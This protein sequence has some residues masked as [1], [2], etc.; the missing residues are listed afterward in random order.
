MN[1]IKQCVSKQEGTFTEH[2]SYIYVN[3]SDLPAFLHDT[4]YHFG[5]LSIYIGNSVL[6]ITMYNV[7]IC[8]RLRKYVGPLFSQEFNYV[9]YLHISS[10]EQT[11]TFAGGRV[12]Y[13]YFNTKISYETAK[14]IYSELTYVQ[15]VESAGNITY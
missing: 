6:D 11:I 15:Y 2:A 4:D 8:I 5:I 14:S 3:V 7:G 1:I 9:K 10:Y 13:L 12:K